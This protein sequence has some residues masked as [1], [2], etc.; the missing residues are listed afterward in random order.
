MCN[1]VVNLRKL[2]KT[3][4]RD[5]LQRLP[6]PRRTLKSVLMSVAGSLLC[7]PASTVQGCMRKAKG[8]DWKPAAVTPSDTRQ[9]C[10]ERPPA[11]ATGSQD[12]MNR[13][14][15]EALFNASHGHADFDYIKSICRLQL[16]GLDM[17]SKYHSVEFAALVEY[18]AGVAVQMCD[19]TEFT[20]MGSHGMKSMGSIG[21]DVGNL[22]RGVFSKHEPGT[23]C[24]VDGARDEDL[25][26]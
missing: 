12:I 18:V 15:R 13:L 6:Q 10:A 1:L 16:S 8:N 5:M 9:P 2:P 19:A 25:S 17:G 24:R 7:L 22:G 11:P 21:F 3:V 20:P 23:Y 14:V 4:T 26:K